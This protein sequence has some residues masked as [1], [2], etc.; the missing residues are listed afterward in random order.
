MPGE[1]PVL[2]KRAVS[3]DPRWT[4]VAARVGRVGSLAFLS[5]LQ[6]FFCCQDMQIIDVVACRYSF[7]TAC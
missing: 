4:R 2:A 7:S 5:I 1:S 3:E 6:V